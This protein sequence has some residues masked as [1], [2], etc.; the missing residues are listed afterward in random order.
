MPKRKKTTPTKRVV[1]KKKKPVE[2]LTNAQRDRITKTTMAQIDTALVA[3]KPKRSAPTLPGAEELAGRVIDL[4]YTI[5]KIV[6]KVYTDVLSKTII[7][8]QHAKRRNIV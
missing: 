3:A 8:L 1:E 6:Q 5:N 2:K 4:R 7:K